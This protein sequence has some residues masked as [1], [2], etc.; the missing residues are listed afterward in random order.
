MYEQ[1]LERQEE[2]SEAGTLGGGSKGEESKRPTTGSL[3]RQE[4]RVSTVRMNWG[5]RTAT[6][7][8]PHG[9]EPVLHETLHALWILLQNGELLRYFEWERQ[10]SYSLH[11]APGAVWRM[12]LQ[13]TK[14]N[15]GDLTGAIAV[16]QKQLCGATK[17]VFGEVGRHGHALYLEK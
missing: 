8:E 6:E 4:L 7:E 1:R 10:H 11:V 13:G 12:G 5:C 16:T 17:V 2:V 14:S 15:R 9:E 3:L